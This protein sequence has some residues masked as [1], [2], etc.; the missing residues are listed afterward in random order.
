MDGWTIGEL[1]H[2]F[3]P[4]ES[5]DFC[6]WVYFVCVCVFVCVICAFVLCVFCV[7]VCMWMCVGVCVCG[8]DGAYLGQMLGLC[9]S[10]LCLFYMWR[11]SSAASS[12]LTTHN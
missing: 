9:G 11:P 1:A 4:G 6:V 3:R 7:C 12:A 5:S 10:R 8:W 2:T